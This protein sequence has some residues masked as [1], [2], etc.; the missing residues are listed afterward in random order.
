MTKNVFVLEL[1]RLQEECQ[2]REAEEKENRQVEFQ[3][4]TIRSRRGKR[5]QEMGESQQLQNFQ[6]GAKVSLN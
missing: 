6:E 1:K 4:S 3:R 2:R 5:Q